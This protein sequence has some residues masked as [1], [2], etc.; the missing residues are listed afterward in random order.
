MWKN[1]LVLGRVALVMNY[2]E[3]STSGFKGSWFLSSGFIVLKLHNFKEERDYVN[4]QKL[5][6]DCKG[7]RQMQMERIDNVCSLWI[8]E[9]LD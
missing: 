8:Y 5:H 2:K 6:I 1:V 3:V 4:I 9:V 7:Q